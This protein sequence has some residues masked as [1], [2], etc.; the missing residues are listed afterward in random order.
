MKLL[1][2]ILTVAALIAVPLFATS[3]STDAHT[4]AH[5][6]SIMRW[7]GVKS[8]TLGTCWVP[9]PPSE[10]A[11]SWWCTGTDGDC[12]ATL[13]DAKGDK[14]GSF[15]LECGTRGGWLEIKTDGEAILT[16]S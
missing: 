12:G 14:V 2:I 13:F 15:D 8:K 6:V 10:T 3:K 7:Y 5:V 16:W 11:Q 4:S 1:S 9:D